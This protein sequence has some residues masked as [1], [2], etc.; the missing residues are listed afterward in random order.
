MKT[1][2]STV[3]RT[4]ILTAV[5]INL[6]C[7]AF[8]RP[9]VDF[10]FMPYGNTVEAFIDAASIVLAWWFDNGVFPKSDGT[11]RKNKNIKPKNDENA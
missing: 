1:A 2:K 8:G 4:V 10:S 9:L 6:I 3:V 11:V 5:V 7:K